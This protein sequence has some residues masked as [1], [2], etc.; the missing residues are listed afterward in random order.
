MSSGSGTVCV[1][2]CPC[3][4]SSGRV[5]YLGDSGCTIFPGGCSCASALSPSPRFLSWFWTVSSGV[6][7][8]F[9]SRFDEDVLL[10]RR[11]L[12]FSH[13]A[14]PRPLG[15][16]YCLYWRVTLMVPRPV[17]FY[18]GLRGAPVPCGL[19]V[20]CH[21]WM[22]L[23]VRRTSP[24]LRVIAWL[25]WETS[26]GDLLCLLHFRPPHILLY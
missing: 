17:F 9:S 24:S 3:H 18:V 7:L 5:P 11:Y 10:L 4:E 20:T 6:P 25:L 19:P 22:P 16:A 1:E 26:R 21:G 13:L 15:P 12:R 14:L 8:C 2:P 23:R